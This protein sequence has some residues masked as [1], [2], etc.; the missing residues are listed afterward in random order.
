MGTDGPEPIWK[1]TRAIPFLHPFKGSSR[2]TSLH[3]QITARGLRTAEARAAPCRAAACRLQRAARRGLL[4][5]L[6]ELRRGSARVAL[7]AAEGPLEVLG[8]V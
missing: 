6:A 7:Q 8:R 5:R 3:G 2:P 4:A 1:T